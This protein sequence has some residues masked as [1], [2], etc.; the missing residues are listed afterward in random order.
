MKALRLAWVM[1][2]STAPLSALAAPP[3]VPYSPLLTQ[4]GVLVLLVL[5][6]VA[7]L[8]AAGL[9]YRRQRGHAPRWTVLYQARRDRHLR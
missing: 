9:R 5:G 8:A 4:A 7:V 2:L 6:Y 1:A 3:Q